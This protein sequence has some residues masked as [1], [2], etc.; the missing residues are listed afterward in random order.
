MPATALAR[1]PPRPWLGIALMAAGVM[2]LPL[3]DGL[4]KHLSE[5]YHV[6]Q[7]TWARYLF[8]FL[9]L[10]ALLLWRLRPGT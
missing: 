6:V 7:V 10:G 8:H 5:Q 3:M 2:T 4:A 9:L 1:R